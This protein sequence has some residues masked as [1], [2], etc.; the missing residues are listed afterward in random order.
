MGLLSESEG[1][2]DVGDPAPNFRLRSVNGEVI[3]L[4]DFEGNRH[5]ILNFWASWTPFSPEE[6]PLLDQVHRQH[7][8]ELVVLG[9]NIEKSEDV[10]RTF[11]DEDVDVSYPILLDPDGSVVR[12]YR[13]TTVPTSVFINR[14]GEIAPIDGQVKKNG[15]FTREELQRQVAALLSGDNDNDSRP[16]ADFAAEPSRGQA[17]LTV[18]F[19]ASVS[20]DP[21]AQSPSEEIISY[22]WDFGD[23]ESGS[24]VQVEH[25]YESQGQFTATLTVTDAEGQTDT[26]SAEIRVFVG[27][28]TWS[29]DTDALSMASPTVGPDGTV[30][31]GSD[32]GTVYALNDDGSE[33]WTFK[34]GGRVFADP[35]IGLLNGTIYVGSSDG[36]LYAINPDGTEKWAFNADGPIGQASPAIGAEGTIYVG[37]SDVDNPKLH[38]VNPD[39]TR[40]WTY[41]G[42]GAFFSPA[43]GSDGTIYVVTGG[44]VG[45]GKLHAIRPDGTQKWAFSDVMGPFVSPAI[46]SDGTIYVGSALG[47]NVYAINPDGSQKWVFETGPIMA[48]P[49]IGPDGTIHIIAQGEGGNGNGT[50]HA[51]NPDGTRKWAFEMGP[52]V[53]DLGATQR[54]TPAIGANEIVYAGSKDGHLYAINPDGSQKWAFSTDDPVVPSPAIASDGTIYVQTATGTLSAVSSESG[55]LADSAWPMFGHDLRHSGRVRGP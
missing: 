25:T 8:D 16:K 40:K 2:L 44:L 48:A 49:S 38:A 9:I 36:R 51:L 15:A 26:A 20:R 24:G 34:T 10:V 23:G 11:V 1:P 35:A 4:A 17:P 55:G 7:R 18:H 3:E 5:V 45:P 6:M 13:I 46:G 50:L 47:G 19:D 42:N 37:T 21:E 30:Y 54:P 33:K 43:I 41:D 39:G 31:V 27:M 29:F 52:A 12:R 14:Q 32:S 53:G 22:E 28:R